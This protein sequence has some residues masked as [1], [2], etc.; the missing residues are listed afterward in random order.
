MDALQVADKSEGAFARLGACHSIYDQCFVTDEKCAEL[1]KAIVCF[2]DYFRTNFPNEN[3]SLK[4]HLLE[5]H[6]VEWV[7]RLLSDLQKVKDINRESQQLY[8][9]DIDNDRGIEEGMSEDK[10]LEWTSHNRTFNYQEL[11]K[12]GAD[13][14]N[15]ATA[16]HVEESEREFKSQVHLHVLG[17]LQGQHL[18]NSTESLYMSL[19]DIR[20]L[21]GISSLECLH[22][23]FKRHDPDFIQEYFGE[24]EQKT[25]K[26]QHTNLDHS[27][28]KVLGYNIA[29]SKQMWNL[30]LHDCCIDKDCMQTLMATE[31]GRAFDYIK[32]MDLSNN[33]QLGDQGATVL[34]VML[35]ENRVLTSLGLQDC[36][37]GPE[38]LLAICSALQV[39]TT[40][41]SLDLSGNKFDDQSKASL[42][43]MLQ[44]NK[45]LTSLVLE[46]YGPYT[47]NLHVHVCEVNTMLATSDD[48]NFNTLETDST[49]SFSDQHCLVIS[50]GRVDVCSDQATMTNSVK[51]CTPAISSHLGTDTTSPEM[52]SIDI[53]LYSLTLNAYNLHK[54]TEVLMFQNNVELK[55]DQE[56]HLAVVLDESTNFISAPLICETTCCRI[57]EAPGRPEYK[58]NGTIC[59]QDESHAICISRNGTI[60]RISPLPWLLETTKE[61]TKKW[62]KKTLQTKKCRGPGVNMQ[63]W[64]IHFLT[65]SLLLTVTRATGSVILSPQGNYT[66]FQSPNPAVFTCS[67][68]GI[69]AVWTLN[70]TSSSVNG[71]TITPYDPT[72]GAV[73]PS[74]LSIIPNANY[75]NTHVACAVVTYLPTLRFL[76][77]SPTLLII[78]GLLGAPYDFSV[79]MSNT[80]NTTFLLSWR[81]PLSLDVTDSP[82]IFYYTLCANITIYGCR[83][84][85]SDPDC[86][87][88][89]TCMSS[90]DFTHPSLNGTNG[91]QNKTIM[92][93]GDPI[94]FTF[95]AVNGAGSG[96]NN[97]YLF[98]PQKQGPNTSLI[99]TE[100]TEIVVYPTTSSAR[101]GTGTE[102]SPIIGGIIAGAL[103]IATTCTSVVALFRLSAYI[104]A[105]RNA[106]LELHIESC[107]NDYIQKPSKEED[108]YFLALSTFLPSASQRNNHPGIESQNQE[109]LYQNQNKVI[110]VH[111][112]VASDMSM[113]TTSPSGNENVACQ[114]TSHSDDHAEQS[115]EPTHQATLRLNLKHVQSDVAELDM[116]AD[117]NTVG[118]DEHIADSKNVPLHKPEVPPEELWCQESASVT[119][120]STLVEAE[121]YN[122][123]T[124]SEVYDDNNSY[125]Y[126]KAAC[127]IP[128][129]EDVFTKQTQI[130]S[131]GIMN[132]SDVPRRG[133]EERLVH[134]LF[135]PKAKPIFLQYEDN[136]VLTEVK[137][138][139]EI[140]E[141]HQSCSEQVQS[142]HQSSAE[143]ALA[144]PENDEKNDILQR[145]AHP[146]CYDC[147]YR[148]L[149]NLD[150]ASRWNKCM[151]ADRGSPLGLSI[152][153]TKC[154]LFS[155]SDLSTFS[156][157]MKRSNVPHFEILE[158]PIGDLVFC[159]K[160]VAQKQ[161][162]AS[163]LLQQLEAVG[164]IDPQGA[165]LLLRQCG[166][167]CR[168]VH[169]SRNTPTPLVKEAFALFDDRV[170]QCFS[171]CTA[172]DASASTWQQAQLSLK[173]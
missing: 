101:T 71:V 86:T 138:D 12:V 170:Q 98:I 23:M 105:R 128:F 10:S 157:E 150:Q 53:G 31:H 22:F 43:A 147:F 102:Y 50:N 38:G 137:D 124:C 34:G 82:D 143:A 44:E 94:Y 149:S 80:S 29:N 131:A 58:Q 168:L 100:A 61:T 20:A 35:R 89:R 42:W 155:L 161:S 72:L 16:G 164:S 139:G 17:L 97:T 123:R 5:D 30:E 21:Q 57:S 130:T 11:V 62:V 45:T 140:L 39:N 85:S 151:A 88:P 122:L 171:E 19:Q 166:S 103:L 172:V 75:N 81:A 32:S 158:A 133:I 169:L 108:P 65:I 68:D 18:K 48:A 92:D 118:T 93:Y 91:G 41:T 129:N 13:R 90:V 153:I 135:V 142:A 120:G 95:F 26:L 167:Y 154:E 27:D 136:V 54:P 49:D 127:P 173:T 52:S 63:T 99:Q 4:M 55:P 107:E 87:F 152:N 141:A 116:K 33:H 60:N 156:D 163:K 125:C 84:I 70:G 64:N 113:S 162:E 47:E 132:S 56:S 134:G 76:Q 46:N 14:E 109:Q 79:A 1:D 15:N 144:L 78:Q 51:E 110:H 96:E 7:R 146:S 25:I 106:E 112:P 24:R 40:L 111:V 6:T 104:R 83:T 77:S 165:L 117:V 2:M 74:H 115:F 73:V 160:F 59:L 9:I 69:I 145:K 121:S 66:V 126:N 8:V 67:G 159:A 114:I 119:G 3:I 37:L 28:C 148:F 36:G